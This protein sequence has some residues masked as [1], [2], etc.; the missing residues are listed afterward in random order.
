MVSGSVVRSKLTVG[1]SVI[2]TS[3]LQMSRVV[4]K[5][6]SSGRLAV[7][8]NAFWIALRMASWRGRAR[9]ILRVCCMVRF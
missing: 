9:K 6:S 3:A 4:T 1:V 7:S 8:D 5:F 2:T